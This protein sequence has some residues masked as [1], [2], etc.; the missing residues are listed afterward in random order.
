MLRTILILLSQEDLGFRILSLFQV[1]AE[2]PTYISPSVLVVCS[3]YT[4]HLES[5]TKLFEMKIKPINHKY[6]HYAF[7]ASR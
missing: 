6:P 7:S 5:I 4:L 3:G 2:N 1:Y